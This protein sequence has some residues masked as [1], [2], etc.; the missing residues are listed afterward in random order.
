MQEVGQYDGA[1]QM[2]VE[3]PRD[4]DPAR[5]NFV[6]WLVENGRLE[7]RTAGPATGEFAKLVMFEPKGT[8]PLAS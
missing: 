8:L 3:E 6:R 5:L 4:A 1:L 2:F 7:H